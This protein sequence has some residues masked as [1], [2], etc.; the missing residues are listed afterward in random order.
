M[1]RCALAAG[2]L[3]LAGVLALGATGA[4]SAVDIR[5]IESFLANDGSELPFE[6]AS[7][8]IAMLTFEDPDG[9]GLGDDIAFLAS[10]RVLFDAGVDSLAII[11]FE[12]GLEPDASGLGYFEKVDRITEGRNFVAALWG[13]ISRDGGELVVDTFVQ[14]YSDRAPRLFDV[15]LDFEAFD[16]PLRASVAPRRIWAQSVRLPL[17]AVAE[18][19]AIADS[20]R[21]L[22]EAP[23][24][25]APPVEHAVLLEGAT[26]RIV[27]RS[28]DWTQVV[29]H[30]SELHGWT[31]VDAFC[32]REPACTGLIAGAGF[33]NEL[34]RY[35]NH[36][37]SALRANG[38]STPTA[39]AVGDQVLLIEMLRD[40]ARPSASHLDEAIRTASEWTQE[41]S[42]PGGAT[43]ANLQSLA[44]LRQLERDGA[45]DPE[46]V[47][48]VA[49][50][51]ARASL[52]D[53]GNLDLLHNLSVLFGFL[54]DSDRSQLAQTLYQRQS[55][56]SGH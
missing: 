22:R 12:Q 37:S 26:Y 50:R 27:N 41:K 23:D 55:A 20:V 30:G 35:V 28:D 49:N 52:D 3:V 19:H 6:G 34:L 45:L 43:F 33:L 24:Q 54:G 17:S 5:S 51:L 16:E 29:L 7:N 4:A 53:P 38:D 10:K 8:R 9:T 13:H 31:S 39:R 48:P 15:E 2:R 14:V 42:A 18:I 1:M 36:R 56:R 44:R 40:R 46:K 21:T 25:A 32:G 47:R 11:L